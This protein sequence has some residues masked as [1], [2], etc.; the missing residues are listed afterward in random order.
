MMGSQGYG[1]DSGNMM[2]GY[3]QSPECQEFY[4]ETAE[5]RKEL[6]V[7]RFE[8]AEIQRDPK[9]TGETTMK[10]EKEMQ[11]LQEKISAKAPS[12]CRW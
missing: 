5:L 8:Y 1:S 6:N 12:G 2:Q 11:E 10:H 7:K 3:N 9:A 4:S